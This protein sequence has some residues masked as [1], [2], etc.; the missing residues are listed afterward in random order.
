MF[1]G[2]RYTTPPSVGGYANKAVTRTATLPIEE[3][4]GQIYTRVRGRQLTIELRS[5]DVGVAWQL[6]S[7]RLDIRPD[8]SR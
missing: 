6:G 1:K 2:L 8:G 7:P 4:T 3:F 5:T